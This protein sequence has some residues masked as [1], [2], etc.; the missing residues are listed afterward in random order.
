MKV[1]DERYSVDYLR[2]WSFE[3][4]S[5]A[6]SKY[7]G[8]QLFISRMI[9]VR[10][11]MLSILDYYAARKHPLLVQHPDIITSL[12]LSQRIDMKIAH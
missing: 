2:R 6:E 7:S 4:A 8:N 3:Y 12:L 9:L 1:D 5:F 11:K 10:L